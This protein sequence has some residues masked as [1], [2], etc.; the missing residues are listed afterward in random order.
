MAKAIRDFPS[1]FQFA[2][3]VANAETY[4]PRP[5]AVIAGMGGS[6]LAA[7]LLQAWKPELQLA[8][9]SDYG[10][11]VLSDDEAK[12]SLF[13]ISSYSGNTEEALDSFDQARAKGLALAV[14][15]VGGKLLERASAHHVPYVQLPDTGIQP[16]SALGYSM[17][18]LLAL[19]G[20][21]EGLETSVHLATLLDSTEAEAQGRALA[22]ALQ[23]SVPIL[24]ASTRNRA[25]AYNWKI[26]LN[27]TGKIPAFYNV[28]PEMN[29][30]E[31]NGFDVQKSTRKLSKHFHWVF[32]ADDMDHPHVQ[33]RM[34]VLQQLYH[35]RSL[36]VT[37]L[38]LEGATVLERMF[39]SLLIADW[40]S[41][42]TAL[43]YHVDPEQVPMV[44]EFKRLMTDVS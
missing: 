43:L 11:P 24:Y 16:R 13:I 35:D 41:Y 19:L 38:P 12:E 10:L 8:V 27:E 23:G 39:R 34:T 28:L 26:K 44:E 14:I 36:P 25:V 17:R 42:Y 31:M 22:K 33:K 37:V 20:N 15:A 5:R 40:C 21:H 30:N 29:H 32:L 9:H 3:V 1:Q 6:H 2:P 4:Q 7:D 18:A